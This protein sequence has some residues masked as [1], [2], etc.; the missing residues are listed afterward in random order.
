MP[1]IEIYL[2]D[3]ETLLKWALKN[4]V[5]IADIVSEMVLN[6][7]PNFEEAPSDN[8]EKGGE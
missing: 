4:K 7:R 1:N 5:P 3:W 2:K 8:E 6:E